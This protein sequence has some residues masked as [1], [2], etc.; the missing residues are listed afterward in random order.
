MK[1]RVTVV[2]LPDSDSRYKHR[3]QVKK[4]SKPVR[5]TA[6]EKASER[7]RAGE[8]GGGGGKTIKRTGR[9]LLVEKESSRFP[10]VPTLPVLVSRFTMC[11]VRDR[12][13]GFFVI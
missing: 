9:G 4:I 10:D 8:R 3:R 6:V 1:P 5:T 2:P 13:G 11:I 12:S 7:R